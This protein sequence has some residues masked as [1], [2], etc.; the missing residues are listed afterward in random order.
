MSFLQGIFERAG[1]VEVATKSVTVQLLPMHA[2]T[3]FR[4]LTELQAHPE[5]KSLDPPIIRV[6]AREAA[7]LPLIHPR[8]MSDNFMLVKT[9][10][11]KMEQKNNEGDLT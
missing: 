1:K 2:P 4:L 8:I 5:W 11:G 3:V 9:I 7:D 10:A 6:G